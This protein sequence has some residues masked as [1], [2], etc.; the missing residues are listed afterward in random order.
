[1]W[2]QNGDY[3]MLTQFEQSIVNKKRNGVALTKDE[4]EALHGDCRPG[5]TGGSVATQEYE[6]ELVRR[7]NAGEYLTISAKK[8]ARQIVRSRK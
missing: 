6:D 5:I 1:V 3:G 4:R 8:W 7:L 2:Y